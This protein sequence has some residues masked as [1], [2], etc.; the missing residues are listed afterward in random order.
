MDNT[1]F[2]GVRCISGKYK[3]SVYMIRIFITII[4]CGF[5]FGTLFILMMSEDNNNIQQKHWKS[6]NYTSIDLR[7]L[8]VSKVLDD[9]MSITDAAIECKIAE[10]SVETYVTRQIICGTVETY[11]EINKKKNKKY[12]RKHEPTKIDWVCG[13]VIHG[14]IEE[15]ST[16]TLDQ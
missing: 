2:R 7:N 13:A 6:K 8:A 15:N 1:Y 5:I 10:H 9:G 12:K 14:F 4:L 11:E 16:I 3:S